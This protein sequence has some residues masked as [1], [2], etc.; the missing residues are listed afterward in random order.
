MELR[1][2]FREH[3]R[4]NDTRF[5]LAAVADLS[6]D[7][8]I[9]K[10]L[11][12][13]VKSWYR[14][15]ET[16]FGFTAREMIGH[17]ITKI[18]PSDRIDEDASIVKRIGRSLN[19]LHF[20][21]ERQCK[22]GTIIPVALTVSP[23]RDHDSRLIGVSKTVQNLT[24]KQRIQRDLQRREA[25]LR[26]ILDD[27]PRRRDRNRPAR[28]YSFLQR[29]CGT[30]V[31]LQVGRDDGSETR[32]SAAV[33]RL[34]SAQSLAG[35]LFGDRRAKDRRIWPAQGW[36]RFPDGTR[37]RRN[38]SAWNTPTCHLCARPYRTKRARARASGDQYRTRAFGAA[39][40]DGA[41]RIGTFKFLISHA[42]WSI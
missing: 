27:R 7:A 3:V 40:R 33:F 35:W 1:P 4:L 21:T 36:Q 39:S 2:D 29:S 38:R 10:D 11:D 30:P 15:A 22:N 31:R 14:A 41:G 34:G 24:E 9:A 16:M 19:T 32:Y 28:V 18:I 26:S 23:I 42:F 37:Y 20:E 8:I 12:G 5:W 25:L 17:S 13:L 6:D